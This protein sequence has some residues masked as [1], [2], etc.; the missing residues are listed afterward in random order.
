MKNCLA[1]I[2]GL[3]CLLFLTDRISAD[4]PRDADS[5]G[6]VPPVYLGQEPP[7]N[8]PVLFAAGILSSAGVAHGT[9]SVSP[10]GSE[11][12][13][14]SVSPDW[15]EGAIYR[16]RF[17]NGK[18]GKP[19][20]ASFSRKEFRDLCPVFHGSGER[21]Y[22][23]STRPID[24]NEGYNLWVADRKGTGW[25][26]PRALDASVNNGCQSGCAW[27]GLER[28]VFMSWKP[29]DPRNCGLFFSEIRDGRFSA[30]VKAGPE[31]NSPDHIETTPFASPDGSFLLFSSSGRGDG[32]GGFD[33]YVSFRDGDGKWLPAKNLGSAFNS[34]GND[35]FPSVSPDG[36]YIFFISDKSG[37]SEYYWV[38][39]GV[40]GNR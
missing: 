8:T 7:G 36:K 21:L 3:S 4:F 20:I 19:Q 34:K 6:G 5:P 18:W 17:E 29:D 39:A 40:I 13:W 28:L 26:E 37:N 11:I 30:A 1:V 10:N 33:L 27:D 24:G 35:W 23:T 22:F 15:K 16:T 12:Y 9:L 31:I 2:L 25:T 32:A 14:S 38:D